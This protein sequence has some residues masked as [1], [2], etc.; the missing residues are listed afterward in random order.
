MGIEAFVKRIKQA[1][2]IYEPRIQIVNLSMIENKAENS[3]SIDMLY[4]VITGGQPQKWNL[5]L[6]RL[7]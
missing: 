4:T 7:K 2:F 1:I 6:E 5:T 3:L